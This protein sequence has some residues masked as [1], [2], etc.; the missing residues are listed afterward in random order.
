VTNVIDVSIVITPN[1]LHHNNVGAVYL[2]NSN[3]RMDLVRFVPL[4]YMVMPQ[5]MVIVIK[6]PFVTTLAHTI[7][8]LRSRPQAP[9][10]LVNVHT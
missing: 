2:G 4:Y 8:G 5:S 7:V 10:Q 9:K 3:L 6:T 1:L